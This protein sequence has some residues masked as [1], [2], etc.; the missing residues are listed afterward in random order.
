[1]LR[2]LIALSML[3]VILDIEPRIRSLTISE[4][5]GQTNDYWWFISIS[6]LVAIA[7]GFSPLLTRKWRKQ[8]VL[9]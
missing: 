1:M 3:M 4:T 2:V 8:R 6:L 5:G 7:I 9:K